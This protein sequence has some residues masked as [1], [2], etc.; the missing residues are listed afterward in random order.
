MIKT[1]SPL[2][3]IVTAVLNDKSGLRRTAESLAAQT[4]KDFKWIVIDG[5]STDGTVEFLK[6]VTL[7]SEWISE[8]DDGI[9]DAWNKGIR[10]SKGRFVALLNAGDTFDVDYLETMAC[11]AV[12][13]RIACCHVRLAT[14]TGCVI[15][16][17]RAEPEKLWRGMHLPHNWCVVP[18]RIYAEIGDYP[19]LRYS[20]D[21]AW[22]H[23]YFL[24]Y[25]RAGFIVVPKV[26]GTYH[27]GG[28][29]DRNYRA[30]FKE[31]ARILR[32]DGMNV[33]LARLFSIIYTVKHC[34][35]Y[36]L[37][38]HQQTRRATNS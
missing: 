14:K 27:L 7:I 16:T 31:N 29:S 3:S 21:F 30:S 4:Y 1:G 12:E 15:G 25:G 17:M 2:F 34:L 35:I 38:T 10:R 26:L 5:G 23:R 37:R 28:L 22:L 18:Q 6:T 24:H 20:M 8:R 36:K 32:K 11:Y 13:D 33:M 9:A 19:K